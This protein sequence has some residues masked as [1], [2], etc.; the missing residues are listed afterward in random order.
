MLGSPKAG[1]VAILAV[2]NLSHAGKWTLC[3]HAVGGF[4]G[5]A[6]QIVQI[7]YAKKGGA[8]KLHAVIV[9]IH[10]IIVKSSD[11]IEGF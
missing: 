1:K 3:R 5:A 7:F 11:L 9:F 10:L 2:K 6:L 4:V 8:L